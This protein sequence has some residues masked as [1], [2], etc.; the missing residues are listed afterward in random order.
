MEK[1]KKFLKEKIATKPIGLNLYQFFKTS[2]LIYNIRFKKIWMI[3][4][5]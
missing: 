4:N 1:L 2:S 3:L 5:I